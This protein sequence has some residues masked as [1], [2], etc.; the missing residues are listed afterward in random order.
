MNNPL[1]SMPFLVCI[2]SKSGKYTKVLTN[3][4]R[5]ASFKTTMIPLQKPY[6]ISG[7]DEYALVF[8]NHTLAKKFIELLEDPDPYM[9]VKPL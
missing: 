8:P 7:V 4:L 3:K 6:R 5:F 9:V 2:M 1:D